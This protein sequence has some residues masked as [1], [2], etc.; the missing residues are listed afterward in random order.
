MEEPGE[1]AKHSGTSSCINTSHF[2][3][4]P[5]H[6]GLPKGHQLP[7]MAQPRV[8]MLFSPPL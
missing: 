3:A 2:V 7:C 4:V 6:H 1:V 8:E 5:S